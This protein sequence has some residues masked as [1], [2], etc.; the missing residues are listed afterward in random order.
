ML[1]T[2]VKLN[3]ASYMV[4]YLVLNTGADPE[5]LFGRGISHGERVERE[6][7]MGVWGQSLKLKAFW[8]VNVPRSRKNDPDFV[9]LQNVH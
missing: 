8:L 1:E 2:H 9:F 6:P 4:L 7:I 5:K 3:S